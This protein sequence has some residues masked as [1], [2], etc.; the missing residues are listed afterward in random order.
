[1]IA[2]I[3]VCTHVCE[4]WRFAL[5]IPWYAHTV[6]CPSMLLDPMNL[7]SFVFGWAE[8]KETHLSHSQEVPIRK[9]TNIASPVK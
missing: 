1:M 7:A 4:L 2:M 6:S 9:E 3:H 8:P 5:S